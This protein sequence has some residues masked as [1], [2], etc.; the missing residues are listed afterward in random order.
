MKGIVFTESLD[1]VST[2]FGE[3]T[4]D[5]LLTADGLASD[6]AFTFPAGVERHIHVAARKLYRDAELPRVEAIR[7]EDGPLE[8]EYR[9]PRPLA[10]F[11]HGLIEGCADHFGESFAVARRALPGSGGFAERFTIT[12]S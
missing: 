4:T 8:F 12:R 10:D 5:A 3:E 2:R 6:D 1:M 7:R 11:A 9:S